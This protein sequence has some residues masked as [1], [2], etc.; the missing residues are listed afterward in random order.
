MEGHQDDKSG[1]MIATK[2]NETLKDLE[3]DPNIKA[4]WIKHKVMKEN[5]WDEIEWQAIARAQ[6]GQIFD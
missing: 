4:H 6:E 1:R 3:D 2:L 5:T